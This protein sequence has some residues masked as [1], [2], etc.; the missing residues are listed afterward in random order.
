MHRRR[1]ALPSPLRRAFRSAAALEAIRSHSAP[2]SSSSSDTDDRE[3]PA[4][5]ALYNYP[6]FAGAYAALAAHLFHRRVVVGGRLLVLP[7]SSVEPLRFLLAPLLAAAPIPA[8]T[9][10]PKL[11]TSVRDLIL[12]LIVAALV[13]RMD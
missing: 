13:L 2:T 12:S 8:A 11:W 1:L 6:A 7:F 3:A 10:V 9:S 5:L 4:T